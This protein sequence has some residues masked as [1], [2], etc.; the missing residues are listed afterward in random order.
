MSER[1]TEDARQIWYS[2]PMKKLQILLS[3]V[4][5]SHCSKMTT[6]VDFSGRVEG[7]DL[8]LTGV[9]ITCE[10]KVARVIEGS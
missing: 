5:C 10:G 6:I 8:I 9:C 2:I 1:F 7:C 4:W 3:N